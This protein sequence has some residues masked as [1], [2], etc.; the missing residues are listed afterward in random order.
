T[1]HGLLRR[2]AAPREQR[3][4]STMTEAVQADAL[5]VWPLPTSHRLHLGDAR[6]LSF[7]DDES[8][9]LVV[10]SPPYWSLKRY[11]EHPG[12]MGDIEDYEQF[13]SELELVW[14]EVLRVLVPG[15]RAVIVVGDVNVSRRVFGRHLVFPLHSDI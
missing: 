10:T 2:S 15:G 8:V 1:E 5:S 13:L 11:N 9:H 7:L 12:Q 3:G 14:R 4:S 6:D